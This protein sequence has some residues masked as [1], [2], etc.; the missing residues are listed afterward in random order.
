[1]RVVDQLAHNLQF[2]VFESLV[3]QYFLDG[4]NLPSLNHRGLK[5]HPKGTI[6]NDSFR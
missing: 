6:S 4:Y 2:S 5:N 3:L 1:M